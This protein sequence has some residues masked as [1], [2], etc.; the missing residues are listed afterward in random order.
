M[1]DVM[2]VLQQ[3]R[4]WY[5]VDARSPLM[6]VGPDELESRTPTSGTSSQ[7]RKSA[8]FW[9]RS[10][11][12]TRRS[13]SGS[14]R[15]VRTGAENRV[16]LDHHGPAAR[17]GGRRNPRLGRRLGG[18]RGDRGLSRSAGLHHQRCPP[19]APGCRGADARQCDRRCHRSRADQP[20][21]AG[22]SP[23]HRGDGFGSLLLPANVLLLM[24]L[25]NLRQSDALRSG[26]DGELSIISRQGARGHD[27]AGQ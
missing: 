3:P 8:R 22:D 7:R 1:A 6:I 2:L 19:V 10:S 4:V 24:S 17:P 20:A 13:S 5:L 21:R 16:R 9:S 14:T 25:Y 26:P 23:E 15:P 18:R 12:R 27:R 11:R